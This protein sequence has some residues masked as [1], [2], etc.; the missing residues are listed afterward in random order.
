MAA[1]HIITPEYPPQCGGVADYT[2][3]V[4]G[5][6]ADAGD[7]VHVWGPDGAIGTT[8]DGFGVHAALGRF[9]RNDLARAAA[10]LDKFDAPRRLLVQWVP[11]G[12]GYR[13][14]NLWF[15][16][17]LW[18]R[19]R[20]G[21]FIEVMVHEPYL[22]FW[23][24]T[25]RQAAAAG[26]H[27]L[28]T[29]VLLQAARRV[30][31]AIPA[32]ELKW[33]PY[34][35]GRDVPFGWLPIPSSLDPPHPGK[36]AALR[37]ELG[38]PA[39][40]LIGH[41]GMFG[42]P[43]GALLQGVLPPILESVENARVL[44]MGAGSDRFRETFASNFPAHARR[45]MATGQLSNDSLA[46]H[47]SA[48]DLLVQPYPDGVSSRR[49]T[50]MAALRLGVPIVTTTGR[51]TEPFWERSRAV[52]LSPVGDCARMAAEVGYLLRHPDERKALAENGRNL[53]TRT[54]DIRRTVAELRSAA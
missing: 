8:K 19:A 24:G 37:A 18:G 45:V 41:L 34:A 6:L 39:E 29:M 43:V 27:R 7:E 4:A 9:S 15:C 20:R 2:R 1:I 40:F 44:L 11:H 49:T 38:S 33:K 52:R 3:Q 10:L 50:A 51:L 25:W 26:V 35:F 47:V 46:V 21:D 36:V 54:F 14:M 53:Y 42:T 5:A 13:A 31:V 48:C 22:A 23:E 32:W 28:M 16:L 12:Y 30:W 17:W